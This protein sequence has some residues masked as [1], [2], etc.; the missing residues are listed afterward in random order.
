[1]SLLAI[2]LEERITDKAI[3]DHIHP[4]SKALV[5][6]SGGMDSTVALYLAS[7]KFSLHVSI[8]D[9]KH[10]TQSKM[11]AK[12]I[13]DICK[14]LELERYSI[15][16]PEI[17]FTPGLGSE[18]VI[19]LG[20]ANSLY[21]AIAGSLAVRIGARYIIGGT[22]KNDWYGSSTPQASPKHFSTLNMLLRREYGKNAP[23]IITPLLY[24]DKKQVAVLGH[25]L[26]VPFD[27]T[28]SCP[29]EG[30]NPCGKCSYCLKRSDALLYLD[31]F[32]RDA[33]KFKSLENS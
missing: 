1:M 4:D 33:T 29:K 17:R 7:K 20:E 14:K 25:I 8:V 22:I 9:Y 16:Y 24:L 10:P 32:L 28:R 27:M 12:A 21:Y 5:L 26:G 31:G 15:D 30:V 23:L 19:H 2:K 3:R 6:F 18:E 11:E 13:D